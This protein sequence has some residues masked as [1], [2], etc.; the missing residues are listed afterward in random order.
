MLN[1]DQ[2]EDPV[3]GADWLK[4]HPTVEGTVT[5][6]CEPSPEGPG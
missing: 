6:E 4:P 5:R 2:R 1:T 3:G